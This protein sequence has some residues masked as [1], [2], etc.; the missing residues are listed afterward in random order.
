MLISDQDTYSLNNI[1]SIGRLDFREED[2]LAVTSGR[3]KLT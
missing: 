2:Y 3:N 1:Q